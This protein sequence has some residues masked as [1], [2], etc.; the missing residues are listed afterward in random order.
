MRIKKLLEAGTSALDVAILYRLNRLSRLLEQTLLKHGVACE[1]YG[2]LSFYAREEV[3]RVLAYL[4]VIRNPSDSVSLSRVINFPARGVGEKTQARVREHAVE[5]GSDEIAA[6]RDIIASSLVPA[7]ARQGLQEFLNV[8]DQGVA[9]IARLPL[10]L[11]LKEIVSDTG[12]LA[13]YREQHQKSHTDSD[14]VGN[15]GELVTAARDFEQ[16]HALQG[17]SDEWQAVVDSFLDKSAL[18]DG[19]QTQTEALQRVK[20]MTVHAA[21][22]LEFQHVFV[23]GL[24]EGIFPHE[25]FDREVNTQE[26]RRLCYVAITRAK[27]FLS[28]FSCKSRTVF[29]VT[30]PQIPSSFFKEITGDF[31]LRTELDPPVF[32]GVAKR[33]GGGYPGGGYHPRGYQTGGYQPRGQFDQSDQFDQNDQF[34]QSSA[35]APSANVLPNGTKVRH[36]LFGKGVVLSTS[37]HDDDATAHVKFERSGTRLLLLKYAQLT[38]VS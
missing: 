30:Q 18:G 33:R 11:A 23:A 3:K 1:V 7:R 37:G 21:K 10:H 19:D 27:E 29:G 14:R 9:H 8:V 28:L 32:A 36:P 5:R 4:R 26:E 6:I 15:I 13:H 34:D 24:E 16:E 38:K 25:G 17:G 20:L 12:L 2:G 22:G 31:L 35:S